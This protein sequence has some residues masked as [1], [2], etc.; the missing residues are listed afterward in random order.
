MDLIY[1]GFMYFNA[2]ATNYYKLMDEHRIYK[3][4]QTYNAKAQCGQALRY[5]NKQNVFCV[6]VD[7][8][9]VYDINTMSGKRPF[10]D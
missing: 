6:N 10:S 7:T 3:E 2:Y 5:L 8:G 4:W 1:I 9:E